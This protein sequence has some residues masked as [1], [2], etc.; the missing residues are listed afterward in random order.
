M[1]SLAQ[2]PP[3]GAAMITH[4]NCLPSAPLLMTHLT[5]A[6]VFTLPDDC[7]HT[8]ACHFRITM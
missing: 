7:V 8:D 1:D 5:L 2:A 6:T 4:Y 3:S